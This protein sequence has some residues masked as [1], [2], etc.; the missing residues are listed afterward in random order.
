M[1]DNGLATARLLR[2][3]NNGLRRLS[4]RLQDRI[5][6][7]AELGQWPERQQLLREQDQLHRFLLQEPVV[8]RHRLAPPEVRQLWKTQQRE[9][10][11]HAQ[12]R[13]SGNVRSA[14]P[15]CA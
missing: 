4:A 8:G 5:N 2:V 10:E 7:N 15:L 14:R 11:L 6:N 1:R 12:D 9:S 3:H 13:K